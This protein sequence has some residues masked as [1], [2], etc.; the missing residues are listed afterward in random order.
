[1][2]LDIFGISTP[3]S[4]S[5]THFFERLY[6]CH[7]FMSLYVTFFFS[8]NILFVLV[9]G[10]TLAHIQVRCIAHTQARFFTST[11][12]SD[13]TFTAGSDDT[14]TPGSNCMSTNK[15]VSNCRRPRPHRFLNGKKHIYRQCQQHIHHAFLLCVLWN[16]GFTELKQGGIIFG[17]QTL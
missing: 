6:M 11:P 9:V 16:T 14:S 7:I 12:V 10:R 8:R 3:V 1:M 4:C 13:D 17:S 2:F 15:Y 5:H